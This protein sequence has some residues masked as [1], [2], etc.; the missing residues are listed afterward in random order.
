MLWKAIEFAIHPIQPLLKLGCFFGLINADWVRA[1][2]IE[3]G[4]FGARLFSF[5]II[6]IG[7][8]S[9]RNF[10][11]LQFISIQRERVE[12]SQRQL[13]GQGNLTMEN[14]HQ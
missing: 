6:S 8:P 4:G 13:S 10:S 5:L 12:V 9:D 11:N 1:I 14:R 3:R 7:I 2:W